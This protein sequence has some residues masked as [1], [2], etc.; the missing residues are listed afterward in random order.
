MPE[1]VVDG[2]RVAVL[3]LADSYGSRRHGLLKRDG[4][5]GAFWLRPCRHVHTMGM[6][7]AIDVALLD[8]DDLVLHTQ[9][10]PPGRF[11]ALR[12]RCRSVVEAEAGAF[13]G[14]GL[15]EGARVTVHPPAP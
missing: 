6:R 5:E 1:L 4:V 14:W 13:E 11:S 12:L 7:F 8:R 15:V 10:M 3:E 2:R 9:T